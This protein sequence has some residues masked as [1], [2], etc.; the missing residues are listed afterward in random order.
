MADKN[1]LITIGVPVYNGEE[2]LI[3]CLDS[4]K[5][6]TY[7][8]LEFLITN[9]G[10]TDRTRE[11]ILDYC[12]QDSR[13]VLIDR[14]KQGA[15]PA[16]TEQCRL[17]KGKYICFCDADDYLDEHFVEE[18]LINNDDYDLIVCD[19]YKF[20]QN[21]KKEIRKISL[22]KAKLS[23]EDVLI[24]QRRI[25]GNSE[26]KTPMDLDLFSSLCGKLYKVSLINEHQIEILSSQI[27]GG[28]D[29]ALFN[30]DYLEYAQSGLKVDRPLYYYFSNPKSFSHNHK[31]QDIEK[32]NL[33]YDEFEKRAKKY[34]KEASY[35]NALNY[36]IYIQLFSVYLIAINSLENKQTQKK[37]VGTYLN[38]SRIKNVLSNVSYKSFGKAF[39]PFFKWAKQRKD[40]MCWFYMKL[41]NKYR[42]RKSK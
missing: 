31:I 40:K 33:Q 28:A 12:N 10:S 35:Y 32:F 4:L 29:D 21:Q 8:N 34:K 25:F 26:P 1:I 23:R 42:L 19:W 24:L 15:G 27:L 36:R 37:Y 3:T 7:T 5:N 9:N 2:Y 6:Q 16:R 41:A 39:K 18:M 22:D 30:I 17:A 11:I 38:T 13:F 14:K 20:Y